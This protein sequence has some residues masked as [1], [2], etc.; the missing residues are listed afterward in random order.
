MGAEAHLE[1]LEVK[2]KSEECTCRHSSKRFGW[3]EEER[4]EEEDGITGWRAFH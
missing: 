3:N 2:N 4:A 1:Y